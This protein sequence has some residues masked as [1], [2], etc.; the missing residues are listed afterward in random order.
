MV[1]LISALTLAL[2]AAA[3]TADSLGLLP[4]Q[5]T[6]SLSNVTC[7]RTS[8]TKQQ[9][10]AAVAEGCRLH[11]A[12]EQLG[13][14]KYPHKFNN[15]EG[16]VFAAAG[17]YQE[18]PILESGVYAGSKSFTIYSKARD[19]ADISAEA[20]GPDRVVFNPSYQGSCVYVGAMTHTDAA[21]RNAFV[22][23][24]E[25]SAGG[26]AGATT[27]SSRTST[28]TSTS[29]KSGASSTSSRTATATP[30]AAAP[31]LAGMGQGVAAGVVAWLLLL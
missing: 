14:S 12:G 10:D 2:C 26:S 8:Y 31:G 28:A 25:V 13:S 21:D 16:L 17:P 4:R 1:N 15:R 18:F 19:G 7:G 6:A 22:S 9:V 20:P 27:S 29:T 5:G 23:C 3:A 30:N 11:A 24:L